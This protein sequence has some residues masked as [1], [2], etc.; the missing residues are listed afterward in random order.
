MAKR[1]HQNDTLEY[2]VSNDLNGQVSSLSTAV[3]LLL[4]RVQ[5]LGDTNSIRYLHH[6][7]GYYIDKCFYPSVV[8]LASHMF[9][10]ED[11]ND[12]G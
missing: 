8:D 7:Y 2:E 3:V 5:E 1:F 9:L 12:H 10:T 4:A 6:A 11:N